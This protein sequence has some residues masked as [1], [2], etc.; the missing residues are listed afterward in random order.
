LILP[1]TLFLG[2]AGVTTGVL[3]SLRRFT[4][5]AFTAAVF[6]ASII[7]LALVGAQRWGIASLAVGVLIGACLQVVLQIP[8][9]HGLRLRPALVLDDPGLRRIVQLYLPVAVGLVIS[10]LG[11]A[12]DR[13]LASRTGEQT[14]AWMA[15]ATTLIQFPLGLVVAAI[16]VAALPTLAASA[17]GQDGEQFRRT[18]TMA[19]RM[20]LVLILPATVWLWLVGR[21]VIAVLFEH[22]EFTAFDSQQTNLALV[23]YLI[24]LPF[25]AIDQPLIYAYYARK[26]TLTPVLVG[27]MAIGVYLVV[28]LTLIGRLGM[29]GLVAANSAQWLSHAL[30]MLGLVRR[31]DGL[32]WTELGRSTATA[33]TAS[34]VMGA[35]VWGILRLLGPAIE[36]AGGAGELVLV[37]AGGLV[38][39]V[40]YLGMLARLG[41]PEP[42]MLWR[43]VARRLGRVDAAAADKV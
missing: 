32:N 11:V 43:V 38:G 30:V 18:L 4:Y 37:L 19:L 3:Y 10:Q 28:A 40:V 23:L 41:A 29:V 12:I 16:S 20:V 9:L 34:L 26:N 22:G 7:V 35:A 5:P 24:G 27:I 21:P 1:A 36:P 6:N 8:G 42:G 33:I 14:I 25:A 13:N 17:S 39:G 31:G 15:A 2:L